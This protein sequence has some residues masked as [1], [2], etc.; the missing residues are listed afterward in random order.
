[1][2]PPY[3]SASYRASECCRADCPHDSEKEPCWGTVVVVGEDGGGEDYYWVHA[4]EGH[5]NC[6]AGD[7]VYVS[8]P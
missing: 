1:M 7:G 2:T 3:R 4:C 8:E 6:Y 5:R